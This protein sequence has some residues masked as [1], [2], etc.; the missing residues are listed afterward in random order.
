MLRHRRLPL[1]RQPPFPRPPPTP[2]PRPDLPRRPRRAYLGILGQND[3]KRPRLAPAPITRSL[4][5]QMASMPYLIDG[6]NLIPEIGLQLDS[7]DDEPELVKRLNLYCRLSRRTGLHPAPIMPSLWG[8][9]IMHSLIMSIRRQ[10]GLPASWCRNRC[11]LALQN[12]KRAVRSVHGNVRVGDP[13]AR[14]R[15]SRA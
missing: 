12:C 11:R 2:A 4:N 14:C 13:D 10:C 1:R 8:S 6:H 3:P 9:W 7:F 15:R 5:H